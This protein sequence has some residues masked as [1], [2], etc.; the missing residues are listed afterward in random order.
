[1]NYRYQGGSK[2]AWILEIEAAK[3][4]TTGAIG[5]SWTGNAAADNSADGELSAAT[6]TSQPEVQVAPTAAEVEPEIDSG[7]TVS[8]PNVAHD[9]AILALQPAVATTAETSS[10]LSSDAEAVVANLPHTSSPSSEESFPVP[11]G[12]FAIDDTSSSTGEI[13]QPSTTDGL[14][15]DV[16]AVFQQLAA[17]A[18]K[19]Q[20]VDA[21]AFAD[22]DSTV[23]DHVDTETKRTEEADDVFLPAADLAE[24]S[25]PVGGTAASTTNAVN[26]NLATSV[27]AEISSPFVASVENASNEV[28]GNDH[29]SAIADDDDHFV[30]ATAALPQSTFNITSG[31]V[32]ADAAT[33]RPTPTAANYDVVTA[34]DETAALDNESSTAPGDDLKD[35]PYDEWNRTEDENFSSAAGPAE[36]QTSSNVVFGEEK[37]EEAEETAHSH[38]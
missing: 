22:S 21:A 20:T 8:L 16:D 11:P 3:E 34:H 30:L 7:K 38:H 26:H 23:R 31:Y 14:F 6:S 36:A 5:A 37:T 17:A 10:Q 25:H 9:N 4:T 24:W 32:S 27:S 18:D 35:T 15:I 2:P 19:H 33:E 13:L 28:V 29:Q 1:L 12:S